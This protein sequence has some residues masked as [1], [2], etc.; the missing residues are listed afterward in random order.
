M[1]NENFG[2]PLIES[3]KVEPR[4]VIHVGAHYAEEAP[5]YRS[6][7]GNNVV[8]FEAHPD[9]AAKMFNNQS[10]NGQLKYEALLS[11]VTGKVV[12]FYEVAN[13]FASSI[14]EPSDHFKRIQTHAPV[15]GVIELTSIRYDDLYR[16]LPEEDRLVHDE[17]N[18]L[19]L[20]TQGSELLVM[21]GM[22]DRVFEFDAISTEYATME[23]YK[24]APRLRDIEEFLFPI[25]ERVFPAVGSEYTETDSD[26]L[27]VKVDR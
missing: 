20:D 13:E 1:I 26:A 11:N 3:F 12:P 9:Y 6:K 7:V 18:I 16:K 4:G 14:F 27:F 5:I 10:T 22:G 15:T 23:Y 21:Q 25:Y 17:C 2:F 24:N 8:W 19:V